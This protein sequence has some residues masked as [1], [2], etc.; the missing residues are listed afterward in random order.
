MRT[1]RSTLLATSNGNT[2]LLILTIVTNH[3]VYH[4]PWLIYSVIGRLYLWLPS[5]ILLNSQPLSLVTTHL[6]SISR[7]ERKKES[8][9]SQLYLTVWDLMDC[10]LPGCSVHG[11]FQARVLEWGAIS[12]SRGPSWPRDRTQVSCIVGR[13]FT[14]RATR[15]RAPL[16]FLILKF[17]KKIIFHN[18]WNCTVLSFIWLI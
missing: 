13:C 15:G 18:K 12:F 17:K 8:E 2:V 1:L 10:S 11:I 4:T 7:K 3:T 14:V 6:F 16:Y 9:I 5:P